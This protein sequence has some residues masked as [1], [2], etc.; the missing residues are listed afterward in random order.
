[1]EMGPEERPSENHELAENRGLMMLIYVLC[2]I[3][4]AGLIVGYIVIKP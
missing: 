2:A 4:I 1:M 3:A